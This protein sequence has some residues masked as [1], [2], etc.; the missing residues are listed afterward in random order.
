MRQKQPLVGHRTV[1]ASDLFNSL[2]AYCEKVGPNLIAYRAYQIW[3]FHS[4]S[5]AEAINV[6]QWSNIG[7]GTVT[8]KYKNSEVLG[9]SKEGQEQSHTEVTCRCSQTMEESLT[10]TATCRSSPIL[11]VIQD[12]TDNRRVTQNEST[13]RSHIE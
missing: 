5:N 10:G 11:G 3:N 1:Q 2:R 8:V 7:V 9:Q 13:T 12:E 4:D 6:M